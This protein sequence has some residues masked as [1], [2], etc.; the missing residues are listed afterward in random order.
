MIRDDVVMADDVKVYEPVNLYGCFLEQGVSVGAF[1]EIGSGV[2]IGARTRVGAHCFIP[3]GVIVEE[4]CFISPGVQ[5]S[6]DRHPEDRDHA[7]QPD[8]VLIKR[9]ATIGMGCII[10]SGITIGERAFVAA[11][12]LVTHDVAD[13]EQLRNPRTTQSIQEWR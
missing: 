8:R 2:R 7:W 9:G 5:V 6:N 4:D 12:T 3:A 1:T 13:G 10:L 11:G